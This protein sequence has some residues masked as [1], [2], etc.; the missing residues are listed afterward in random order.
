MNRY[1]LIKDGLVKNIVESESEI[2][3]GLTGMDMHIDVTGLRVGPGYRYSD[4]AFLPPDDPKPDPAPAPKL[5]RLQF[6]SLF[7]FQ[8]LVAIETAAETDPVVRVLKDSHAIA[9]HID[10]ADP[11]TVYGL[12]ILRDKSLITDERLTEILAMVYQS[13]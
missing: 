12:R 7:T 8:E 3:P 5:T 13:L 4:G 10:L 6:R 11:R 1:A 9:D 2:D